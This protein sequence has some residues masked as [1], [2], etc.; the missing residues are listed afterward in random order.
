MAT[1]TYFWN[2]FDDMMIFRSYPYDSMI[3]KSIGV[4]ICVVSLSSQKWTRC[5]R[6]GILFKHPQHFRWRWIYRF[7]LLRHR[8]SDA[9]SHEVVRCEADC[10]TWRYP[11]SVPC[12]GKVR[13]GCL[14]FFMFSFRCLFLF[15]QCKWHEL[16]CLKIVWQKTCRRMNWE[17]RPRGEMEDIFHMCEAGIGTNWIQTEDVTFSVCDFTH[18]KSFCFVPD[19]IRKHR[20]N[21][22]G[23]LP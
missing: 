22:T 21:Q 10:R 6:S 8:K 3:H 12:S 23:R 2:A 9:W 5:F 1:H 17:K 19:S 14:Y 18:P 11:A 20:R 4:A 13:K 16:I 7:T 15:V